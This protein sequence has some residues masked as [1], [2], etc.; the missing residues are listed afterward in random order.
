MSYD[1]TTAPAKS[2]D[3]AP[4]LWYG[5]HAYWAA[6]LVVT[7][8]LLSP[9]VFVR[10]DASG[11]STIAGFRA[12]A[13]AALLLFGIV[14]V[15]M[16][17]P[18]VRV[19]DLARSIRVS[20]GPVMWMYLTI[21][22]MLVSIPFSNL[23]PVVPALGSPARFDGPLVQASWLGLFV[24]SC[25][26]A[27]ARVVSSRAVSR[28]A[29]TGGILTAGWIVLQAL[30]ADPVTYLSRAG[31]VLRF[32]AGAFGRGGLAAAYVAVI[33]TLCLGS[34]AVRRR[35]SSGGIAIAGLLSTAMVATG[36][37]GAWL[38]FLVGGTSLAW[39]SIRRGTPWRLWLATAVVLSAGIP[40]GLLIAPHARS[41]ITR[42]ESI[43]SG[44][45]ATV[46]NRLVAWRAA[47]RVLARYPL[48]GVGPEGFNYAL[49]NF[50]TPG[51][52]QRLLTEVLRFEPDVGS[53]AIS[54]NVVFVTPPAAQAPVAYQLDWDKAHNYVIDVA[55]A[56]GIPAALAM[57]AATLSL[58]VAL[59]R[60]GQGF[61]S[62]TGFALV[63]FAIYAQA[64]FPTVSV[65]PVVW[66]V[67]GAALGFAPRATVRARGLET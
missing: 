67:A 55:L 63:A 13:C 28:Y 47:T 30:G 37:R 9:Q 58:L 57:V 53:F 3:T 33:L 7:P 59:F 35:L 64:W 40:L 27:A 46:S 44:A 17:F 42:S 51:E 45:D 8:L 56:T 24:V 11:L 10:D 22:L 34:I 6:L 5:H 19:R 66:G 50:T 62:T 36:G 39:Y 12:L 4:W 25:G 41:Q 2:R 20:R 29:A 26:L 49:W 54:G 32:P 48:F 60:A 1:T 38:G 61:S 43:A 18:D 21:A 16:S 15:L 23:A 52:Q 14:L 31:V 65:D